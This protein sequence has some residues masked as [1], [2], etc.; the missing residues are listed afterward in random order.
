[1]FSSFVV[2][3]VGPVVIVT[4]MTGSTF[5]NVFKENFSYQIEKPFE[6]GSLFF[7]G[8]ITKVCLCKENFRFWLI[9]DDFIFRDWAK[10]KKTSIFFRCFMNKPIVI[11]WPAHIWSHKVEK[12][13]SCLLVPRYNFL[14]NIKIEKSRRFFKHIWWNINMSLFLTLICINMKSKI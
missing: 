6:I 10:K 9:N 8:I 13:L 2:I 11:L 1:M 3:K 5:N 14:L 7:R 12:K 4:F